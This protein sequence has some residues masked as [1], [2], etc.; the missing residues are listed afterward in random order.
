MSAFTKFHK[1][2][3]NL[4]K[5]RF[6]FSSDTLKVALSNTAP[7]V[8]TD[9]A[10]GD[11]TQIGAGNGYSSGGATVPDVQWTQSSGTA[12]L[13]GDA[14]VFTASGG[15]INTFRYAVI[16]DSTTG[17]LMGYWDYGSTV[18]ITDGNTF[19]VNLNNDPTDGTILTV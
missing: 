15:S 17:Y 2:S 7:T 18:T 16:Y 4:G 14:V 11:I 3:L 1:F 10:I 19:T 6:N 13:T 12:T 5:A 8:A 9:E